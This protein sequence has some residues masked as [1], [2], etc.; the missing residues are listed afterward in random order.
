MFFNFSQMPWHYLQV[1]SF[2]RTFSQVSDCKL[3]NGKQKREDEALWRKKKLSVDWKERW[4]REVRVLPYAI[5]V[6]LRRQWQ[7]GKGRKGKKGGKEGREGG[8]PGLWKITKP[9]VQTGIPE[10]YSLS[11]LSLQCLHWTLVF[12]LLKY[13]HGNS[14]LSALITSSW[15]SQQNGSIVPPPTSSKDDALLLSQWWVQAYRPSPYKADNFSRG[16]IL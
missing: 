14:V 2:P 9:C 3:L 12:L 13:S 16:E 11:T 6:L 1:P 15:V 7:G 5:A 8:R 4:K 10:P